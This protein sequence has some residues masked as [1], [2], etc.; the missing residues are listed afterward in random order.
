MNFWK[1]I[2]LDLRNRG[3]SEVPKL[4]VG[5]GALG[6]WSALTEVFPDTLSQRCWVHKTR[7]ILD[8]LPKSLRPQ[9]KNNV[10]SMYMAPNK[11]EAYKPG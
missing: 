10:Q 1:D 8:K 4:A 7:N 2:L 3:L 6:F 9:A 5:D 11:K